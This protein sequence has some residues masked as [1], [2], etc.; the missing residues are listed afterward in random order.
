MRP[1]NQTC[2]AYKKE[3]KRVLEDLEN[4]KPFCEEE[5]VNCESKD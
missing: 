3:F 2:P 5:E 4:Y 1:D